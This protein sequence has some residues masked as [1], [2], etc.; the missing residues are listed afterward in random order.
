M[1]FLSEAA[2]GRVACLAIFIACTTGS[3]FG[4]SLTITLVL[5]SIFAL[6]DLLCENTVKCFTILDLLPAYAATLYVGINVAASILN[7][8]ATSQWAYLGSLLIF[9]SVWP[10]IPWLRA[11]QLP[12]FD[13]LVDGARWSCLLALPLALYQ[14]YYLAERAEGL[15][16]NA[17]PFAQVCVVM[18]TL[19][20]LGA[21]EGTTKERVLGW[22]G[23]MSA[24]MCVALSGSKGVLPLPLIALVSFTFLNRF[25]W[26]DARNFKTGAVVLVLM[27]AV[28][29]ASP[30]FPRYVN[31]LMAVTRSAIHLPPAAAP[32][33]TPGASQAPQVANSGNL[34]RVVKV[35]DTSFNDRLQMWAEAAKLIRERPIL[36]HGMP[37][38]QGLIDRLHLSYSHFHN[39]FITAAVDSGL[40]GMVA[41]IF[42]VATPAYVAYR[43]PGWDPDRRKKLFFGVALTLT[44]GLGGLTNLVFGHDIYDGLFIF[45][46]VVLTASTP[47]GA[48]NPVAIGRDLESEYW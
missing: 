33:V 12:L 35:V 8:T 47:A 44:Y 42:L 6:V 43:I 24:F 28:T 7:P 37:N 22:A 46:T 25:S 30:T 4:S 11:R 3:L 15:S 1:T 36:G 9:L 20:L 32:V 41:L 39:G 5:F 26:N 48:G 23:F 29:F 38:R 16:G 2:R 14:Y 19:S 31:L 45:M 21:N 40:I 10:I 17:L 34:P 27:S 18:G 13:T